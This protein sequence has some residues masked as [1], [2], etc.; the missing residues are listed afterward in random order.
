MRA[1]A[2][3][4]RRKIIAAAR[5]ILATM[6]ELGSLEEIARRA[7]VG[8]ATLY[9][10]FPDRASL[11]STIIEELFGQIT[12][13]QRTTLTLMDTDPRLGWE[14]YAEGLINLGLAQLASSY[15]ADM[16]AKFHPDVE[17]LR[18]E[19]ISKNIDIVQRA[20]EAGLVSPNVDHL[21]FL[22]GLLSVAR[23]HNR[24]V[25]YTDET[26]T[27]ELVHTFLLGLKHKD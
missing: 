10:N 1:D 18:N 13:L 2:L 26:F 12:D 25:F 15:T 27:D 5:E 21:F 8:I 22:R 7:G 4:R 3:A 24:T 19:L 9:R 23:P 16:V 6:P 14:S 17:Q 20:Q 11:L